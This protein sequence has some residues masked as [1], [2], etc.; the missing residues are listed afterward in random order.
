MTVYRLRTCG[1]CI[2]TV[3]DEGVAIFF[4]VEGCDRERLM[5]CKDGRFRDAGKLGI[6]Y[7]LGPGIGIPKAVCD[8]MKGRR[9]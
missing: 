7:Y 2:V 3:V 4:D 8:V 5:R 1:W 6:W 9:W